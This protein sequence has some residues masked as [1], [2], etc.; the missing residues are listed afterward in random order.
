ME[1]QLFGGYEFSKPIY[2][3]KNFISSDQEQGVGNINTGIL[4]NVYYKN[5]TAGTGVEYQTTGEKYSYTTITS[6]SY[7]SIV[8]SYD[9]VPIFDTSGNQ[10]GVQVNTTTDT[11]NIPTSSQSTVE[12]K[13]K[14]NWVNIP[15]RFGYRFNI[16]SWAIIPRVGLNFIFG[17]AND[18]S[19]YFNPTLNDIENIPTNTFA[20]SY[21]FELEIR[22]SFN[23]VHI[24]LK[25]H[26]N[27]MFT[28][29]HETSSYIRRYSSFGGQVGIG[30]HF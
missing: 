22:K 15:I 18:N 16:N 5:I 6:S 3:P 11:I 4:F 26:F 8:I 13:N 17:V 9:S 21:H 2:K 28:P 12:G 10:V 20:M 14:Y 27:G 29:T 19:D 7:D 23:Q 25:P 24:F 30:F 1:L